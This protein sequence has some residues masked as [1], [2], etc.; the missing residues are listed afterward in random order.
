M[1]RDCFMVLF[2]EKN[3]AAPQFM[4][5]FKSAGEKHGLRCVTKD[6]VKESDNILFI[7]DRSGIEL[8][9]TLGFQNYPTFN[10]LEVRKRWRSKATQA[11]LVEQ[12]IPMPKTR[13]LREHDLEEDSRL[14]KR[15]VR[16]IGKPF[17]MK[18]AVSSRG[19]GVALVYSLDQFKSL[20]VSGYTVMQEY[21]EGSRGTDIRLFCVGGKILGAM[22]R[23]NNGSFKSNIAQGG[24]GVP[25]PIDSKLQEIAEKVFDATQM[26]IVGVDVLVADDEYLVCEINSNPGIVGING[27]L[28]INVADYIVEYCL[29]RI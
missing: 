7:Q 3:P 20:D 2:H 22:Q 18:K 25:Y 16:S 4:P 12:D 26:D 11:Y 28:N 5:Y 29:G 27:A 10:N 6:T 13:I 24:Y 15:M 9:G 8:A 23:I 19:Q 1:S 17:I 21:I 14:F